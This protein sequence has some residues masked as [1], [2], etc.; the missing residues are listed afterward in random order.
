MLYKV[1]TPEALRITLP[2]VFFSLNYTFSFVLLSTNCNGDS[3]H[4]IRLHNYID[5]GRE[6][7]QIANFLVVDNRF[8]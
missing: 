3:S 4:S 1:V 5:M 7:C 6:H 2:P 8:L